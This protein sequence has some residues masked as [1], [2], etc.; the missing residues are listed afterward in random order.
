MKIP[1]DLR[2]AAAVARAAGWTITTTR[3]SHLAWRP[4]SGPTVYSSSTPSDRR[5]VANTLG[6]LRRAGLRD[7]PPS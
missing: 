6:K 4:P 7:R 1:R 3:N 2:P 5:A